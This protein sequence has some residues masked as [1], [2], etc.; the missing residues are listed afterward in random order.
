[1]RSRLNR[2]VVVVLACLSALAGASSAARAEKRLA[3]V[4]ANQLY[5]VELGLLSY[6]HRDDR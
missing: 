5:N 6:T 1:M 2:L 4:I 3:L